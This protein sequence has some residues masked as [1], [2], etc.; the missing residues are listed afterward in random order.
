[1]NF[2]IEFLLQIISVILFDK[3]GQRIP[4]SI[5]SVWYGIVSSILGCVMGA[6]STVLFSKPL[7]SNFAGQIIIVIVI[8]FCIGFILQAWNKM[9]L[10]L[11]K[12][13]IATFWYGF[14]FSFFWLLVRFLFLLASTA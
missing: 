7:I 12:P 10:G 3:L 5:K 13:S 2:I 1:M 14:F 11:D 4:Q 9:I 8:P 6:W